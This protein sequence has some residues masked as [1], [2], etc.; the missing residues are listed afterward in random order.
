M[1]LDSTIKQLSEEWILTKSSFQIEG[2]E[3]NQL[4]SFDNACALFGVV[5]IEPGRFCHREHKDAAHRGCT[6]D[7]ELE[8]VVV[9]KADYQLVDS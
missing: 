4:Q 6:M 3:E 5:F 8:F 1:R 2:L 7:R 9:P